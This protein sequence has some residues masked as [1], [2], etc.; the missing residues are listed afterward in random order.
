MQ[1]AVNR[2]R[3]SVMDTENQPAAASDAVLL[4][5][6]LLPAVVSVHTPLAMVGLARLAAVVRHT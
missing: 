2:E 3:E 5:H 1:K 4:L 6:V